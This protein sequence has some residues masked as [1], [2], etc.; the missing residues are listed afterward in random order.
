M[1]PIGFSTGALARGDF[2]RGLDLLKRAGLRKIELSALRTEELPGLMH[3][4]QSSNLDD[5]DYVSIHAPSS[6]PADSEAGIV[7]ALAPAIKKRLHVVVHPDAIR[8]FKPWRQFGDLLCV[9]NMDKRKPIGRT[10]RELSTVF[11][12]LPEASFCLDVAHTRQ[13][14]PTMGAAADILRHYA[15]R[16]AQVHVSDVNSSSRHERLNLAASLAFRKIASSI[17]ASIPLILESPLYSEPE[18]RM[19]DEI[20]S[21]VGRA[22]S[23]FKI[24]ATEQEISEAWQELKLL[25]DSSAVPQSRLSRKR[26]NTDGNEDVHNIGMPGM[27]NASSLPSEIPQPEIKELIT[28]GLSRSEKM[29]L[30][31]Y[32][33]EEMTVKEIGDALELSESRVREIH[34]DIIARLKE[35]VGERDCMLALLGGGLER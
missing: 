14:D 26:I 8:D 35:R 32:Y 10:A 15:N 5:F 29:I 12:K 2:S 27:F 1:R 16:L 19:P 20:A 17:P 28:R 31:L 30:V 3:Y 25:K 4:I 24:P 23:A 33:Y 7:E 13:V 21:E 22:Q 18:S 6:Y 9:E 11:E 34:A